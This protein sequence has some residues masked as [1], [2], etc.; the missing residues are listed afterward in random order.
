MIKFYRSAVHCQNSNSNT[1]VYEHYLNK[2]TN[3]NF[4]HLAKKSLIVLFW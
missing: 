2:Q 4:Y 3:K 1:E